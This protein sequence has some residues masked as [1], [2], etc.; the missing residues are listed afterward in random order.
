MRLDSK[1]LVSQ[2]LRMSCFHIEAELMLSVSLLLSTTTR[3][4]DIGVGHST[5]AVCLSVCLFA[6][7]FCLSICPCICFLSVCL[8]VRHLFLSVCLSVCLSE[9]S[10]MCYASI[11]CQTCC[12]DKVMS[13]TWSRIMASSYAFST[14]ICSKVLRISCGSIFET[15]YS[16]TIFPDCYQV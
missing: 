13:G 2:L 10:N 14:K 8:S 15:W 16:C 6:I 12:K 1:S 9:Y 4:K 5:R 11:L 7:C 3:N